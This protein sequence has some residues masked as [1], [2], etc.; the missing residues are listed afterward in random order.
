MHQ[1]L[2]RTFKIYEPSSTSCII[3]WFLIFMAASNADEQLF[4]GDFRQLSEQEG[5]LL[6]VPQGSLLEKHSLELRF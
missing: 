2:E 4:Y 5:F 1:D 3:H 6:I